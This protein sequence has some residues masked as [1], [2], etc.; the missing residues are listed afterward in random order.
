MV[1]LWLDV[2]SGA[3]PILSISGLLGDG[4]EPY[5]ASLV[6]GA[7]DAVARF[8]VVAT[9]DQPTTVSTDE[10]ALM[11]PGATFTPIYYEYGEA[12]EPT[13]LAGSPISVPAEGLPLYAQYVN[14]G[15][16]YLLTSVTDIWGNQ[17]SEADALVLTE[18]L[19]P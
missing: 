9:G 11:M 14:P 4:G 18:A 6:F 15:N 7:G 1:D 2:P 19:G 5:W 12:P 3:Q 16:Y 17:S 13:P 8:L 10:L